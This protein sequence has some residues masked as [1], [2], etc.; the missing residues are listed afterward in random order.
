MATRKPS[1]LRG[2]SGM[3]LVVWFH[4]LPVLLLAGQQ[5]SAKFATKVVGGANV[6]KDEY[7]YF[8]A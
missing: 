5:V 3:F 6:E 1:S 8:G 7:P 4:A 2:V